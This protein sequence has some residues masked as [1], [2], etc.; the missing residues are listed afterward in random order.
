MKRQYRSSLGF[1][2]AFVALFIL[3]LTPC[4]FSQNAGSPGNSAYHNER[5]LEHF[6][7]GFYES[8]PAGKDREAEQNYDLAVAELKKAIDINPNS[9]EAHANL[10]RVQYVRKNFAEAAGEYRRVLEIKP[11]D[12]DTHVVL[13]LTYTRMERY[14]EAIDQLLVAK[15]RTGDEEILNKL[16]GYL[17]KIR[18]RN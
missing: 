12:I 6:K 5:G 14:E 10:A 17:A 9:A 3:A 8:T 2:V 7:K 18:N 13:A 11:N 1:S 16:D 4:G 15:T